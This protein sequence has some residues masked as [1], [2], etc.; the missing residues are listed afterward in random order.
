MTSAI[1]TESLTRSFRRSRMPWNR[2]RVNAVTNVT[3]DIPTG[4]IYGLVGPNGAGKTTLM[5][6]MLGLLQ[7]TLGNVRLLG[8][9]HSLF[10]NPALRQ[11]GA[12]I[13][14]P[15]F[16]PFLSGRDNLRQIAD[17][18][19][20][21]DDKVIDQ[22]LADVGLADRGDDRVKT[23]SLGMRQRLGL[24]RCFLGRPSLLILDEPTNGMDPQG[25]AE[26]RELLKAYAANH[27]ATILLSSHLLQGIEQ[28]CDSVAFMDKGKIV[29]SGTMQS[30]AP[31]N[32]SYRIR[33]PRADEAAAFL[34]ALAVDTPWV[35]ISCTHE[36]D[37]LN[38][39]TDID[40]DTADLIRR[41]GDRGFPVAEL[42]P[43]TTSLEDVYRDVIGTDYEVR[44]T[45]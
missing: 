17:L 9:Q 16:L 23:Y 2:S 8:T 10:G 11:V 33:V 28:L 20:V 34:T 31:T 40:P 42:T 19:G 3:L 32:H 13:E 25:I 41:L 45:E 39:T 5:R 1:A 12:L 38:L 21:T 18:L 36:G 30:L 4:S 29:R 37:M 27:G 24:A 35:L 22:A 15:R 26:T 43:L 6:L 44:W 7:P 14:E